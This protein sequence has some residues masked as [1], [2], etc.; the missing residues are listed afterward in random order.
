M[1]FRTEYECTDFEWSHTSK[2][3]LAFIGDNKYRIVPAIEHKQIVM[4]IYA[5]NEFMSRIVLMSGPRD[6]IN[7][8]L[9]GK[10][11]MQDAHNHLKKV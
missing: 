2:R 1:P 6:W 11:L 4:K 7:D 9:A 5:D 3:G 10:F 8:Y